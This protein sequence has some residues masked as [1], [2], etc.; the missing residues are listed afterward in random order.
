MLAIVILAFLGGTAHWAA[1]LAF[2]LVQIRMLLIHGLEMDLE[3]RITAMTLKLHAPDLVQQWSGMLTVQYLLL[4]LS[5]N[6]S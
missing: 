6:W 1:T 4:Y 5:R 2:D 3:S